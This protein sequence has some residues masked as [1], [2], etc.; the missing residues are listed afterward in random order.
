VPDA[1][2]TLPDY[3]RAL[4][5]GLSYER[6]RV[7]QAIDLLGQ[8]IERDPH[9]GPALGLAAW[10]HLQLDVGGWTDRDRNRRT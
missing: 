3:L 8:A 7:V 2:I 10:C 1:Q 6:D 4:P 5:H 9:Y